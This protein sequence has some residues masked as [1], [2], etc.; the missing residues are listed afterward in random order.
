MKQ[1]NYFFTA[2]IAV[3]VLGCQSTGVIPID[4]DS[5]LIGKKDGTPGLG[6]S[7]TN[8]ADVYREAND[9][10]REKGLEVMTLEVITT[11]ARPAQLGST[12]LRFRCVKAG[13]TAQPLQ[14]IPDTVIE[15]RK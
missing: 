11:P 3:F 9:F 2:L 7:L 12:E 1:L 10:C 4:Q 14:K 8:K 13:G 5:Y 15:I 6:V